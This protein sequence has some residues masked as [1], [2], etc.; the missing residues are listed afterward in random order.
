M[1]RSGVLVEDAGQSDGLVSRLKVEHGR[2]QVSMP[3][4]HDRFSLTRKA[5]LRDSATIRDDQRVLKANFQVPH[6]TQATDLS[7]R[8]TGDDQG[9]VDCIVDHRGRGLRGIQYARPDVWQERVGEMDDLLWRG[10]LL[11]F[12]PLAKNGVGCRQ[13]ECVVLPEMVWSGGVRCVVIEQTNPELRGGSFG[14][15]SGLTR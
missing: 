6:E 1:L 4:L 2:V 5:G 9:R 13:E 8:V 7:F 11:A 15:A 3:W 10:P 14:V 12:L